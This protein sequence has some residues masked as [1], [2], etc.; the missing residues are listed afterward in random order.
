MTVKRIKSAHKETVSATDSFYPRLRTSIEPIPIK[1]QDGEILIG[2]R[3]TLEL[4]SRILWLP[5]DLF[6]ILRFFDGEH[7]ALD[8]RAEY[9]RKFGTF[10]LEEQLLQF[11]DQLDDYYLLDNDRAMQRMREF[12]DKYRELPARQ[13]ICAGSCYADDPETLQRELET[14]V[15]KIEAP[16]RLQHLYGQQIRAFV[17]PHIDIRLGGPVYAHAYQVLRNSPPADLYIILGIG[18]QG[19]ANN[20]ALTEKDFDTPFGPVKTDVD[21]VRNIDKHS[22]IDF[23][24]DEIVHINEHSVEFQTVFLKHFIKTDFRILPILCS[25]SSSAYFEDGSE[26]ERLY[27]FVSALKAALQDYKGTVCFVASIDLAHVGPKYGDSFQPS[28][29]FLAHVEQNDRSVLNALSQF[30]LDAFQRI[31]IGNDNRFRICGY[32]ALTTMLMTMQPAHGEL[33]AYDSAVMDASRSTVT[34]ASMV[35]H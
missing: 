22:T 9:L 28:P 29:T 27:D 31:V 8:I 6:Y 21:L 26:K 1:G 13:A 18:H 10:L 17:V 7:S 12:I 32:S 20:F 24:R 14:Y 5:Q 11:I 30:D 16:E 19:L 2:L 23:L 34:F 3:D 35:F 25:F 4:N 33:L 15:R